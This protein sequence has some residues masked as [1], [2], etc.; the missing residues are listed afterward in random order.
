M[1]SIEDGLRRFKKKGAA[2]VNSDGASTSDEDK[3]RIQMSLDVEAFRDEV[4]EI[5]GGTLPPLLA[6]D[7]EAL[8]KLVVTEASLGA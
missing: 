1:K 8:V 4:T 5:M 3:I 7:L 6:A 2:R